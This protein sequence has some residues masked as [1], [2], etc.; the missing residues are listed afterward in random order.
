ME[1][2]RIGIKSLF[3]FVLVRDKTREDRKKTLRVNVNIENGFT[4]MLVVRTGA[5]YGVLAFNNDIVAGE[6]IDLF[7]ACVNKS[8]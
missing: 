1:V 5:N 8:L 2:Y 4:N 7:F 6:F 3:G